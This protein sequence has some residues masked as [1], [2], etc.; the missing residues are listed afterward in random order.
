MTE[1][2]SIKK[3]IEDCEH[4]IGNILGFMESNSDADILSCKK[5]IAVLKE[6]IIAL[7]EIQQYRA[8]GTVGEFKAL[9]EK[10]LKKLDELIK[11]QLIG[12][13]EEFKALKESDM[14]GANRAVDDFANYLHKIAKENNGL[15]LSSETK[16]WTTPCIFDYLEEFKN[17]QTCKE[18]T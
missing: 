12:T 2:E 13:I 11:Y 14:K 1:N 7:E 5:N 6:V 9:K 15:R 16:S 3:H 4:R 17:E 8:I 10:A 18:E